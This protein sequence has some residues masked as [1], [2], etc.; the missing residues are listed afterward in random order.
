MARQHRG[1][2]VAFSVLLVIAAAAFFIGSPQG[3]GFLEA[4]GTGGFSS[5][6]GLNN[7][8]SQSSFGLGLP[9]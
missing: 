6:P 9:W 3:H 4:Y 7:Q 5:M 8:Y 1:M 2:I